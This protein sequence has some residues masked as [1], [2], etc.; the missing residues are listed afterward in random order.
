MLFIFISLWLVPLVL[1]QFQPVAH[2]GLKYSEFGDRIGLFGTFDQLSFY[3]FVNASASLIQQPQAN[4]SLFVQDVTNNFQQRVA[5][6]NGPVDQLVPISSTSVVILGGF[7]RIN[8]K[9]VSHTPIIYNI[10]SGEIVEIL[11]DQV[12][13]NV[14]TVY[15]DDDLI[16][17]GGDFKFNNTYSSAIYDISKKQLSITPFKGFESNSKITSIEKVQDSIIFA[18]KFNKLG[19]QKNSTGNITGLIQAEQI[20]SLKQAT[21]TNVNSQTQDSSTIIC[22]LTNTWNVLANEGG[23]WS[24]QFQQEMQGINPTKARLYIPPGSNGVKLFRIYSFPANGIMNLSYIDP[25]TNQLTFCDAWCPLTDITTLNQ[26]VTSQ[27]ATSTNDTFIDNG[28]FFKYVDDAMTNTLGYG[29][30]FQEFSFVN[31]IPMDKLT[32]TVLDWFGEYGSLS[33]VELF[34]DSII[35]YGNDLLNQPNCN[36]AKVSHSSITSGDFQSIMNLVPGLPNDYLVSQDL[37][38]SMVFYPNITYSGNYS[39]DI[40][41]PGCIQDNS[42]ANRG[43]VNVVVHNGREIVSTSLIHQNNENNKYDHLYS[44]HFTEDDD[45]TVE[46]TFNSFI[47]E[48]SQ[49]WI[50]VDK[51]TVEL[52]GL[53]AINH[54][55]PLNGLFEYLPD[56]SV[57]IT[58]S[59]I[60]SFATSYLPKDT[61]V[62]QVKFVDD[63]LFVLNNSTNLTQLNLESTKVS[64]ISNLPITNSISNM[65]DSNGLILLGDFSIRE[66]LHD[67]STNQTESTANN[68]AKYDN[69]QWFSFG[70]HVN[71][72]VNTF[73]NTTINNIEYYIFSDGSTF[74]NWDNSNKSWISPQF[75]LTHAAKLSTTQQILVGNSFQLMNYSSTNQAYVSSKFGS[76]DFVTDSNSTISNSFYVNSSLS[77]IGGSFTSGNITNIAL[78]NNADPNTAIRPLVGTSPTWGDSQIQSLY[79]D[80]NQDY[81]FIGVNGPVKLQSNNVT[82]I[83]VYSLLNGTFAQVQPA[84]LS[85]TTSKRDDSTIQVNSMVMYDKGKKLLVGGKFDQAGS[86]NCVALCVYDIANTRWLNPNSEQSVDISGT[87][88][89]MKFLTSNQAL[90]SGRDLKLGDETVDFLMYNFDTQS[91]SKNDALNS[92]KQVQQFIITDNKDLK[93]ITMGENFIAGFDGTSWTRIDSDL[94]Y[95]TPVEFTDIKLLTVAKSTN[96]NQ[97]YF[98][99][100][101]ILIL[102]GNFSLAQYGPV[103]AALFNGSSWIPYIFTSESNHLGTIKSLLIQDSY[104]YQS[105][106]DLM[107]KLLS[108]GKIVGISFAAAVGST[109]V[110]AL[111]Y[112]V[113]YL[114]LFKR[115][116][117]RGQFENGESSTMRI[118]ENE[119]LDVVKP[120]QLLHEIDLQRNI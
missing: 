118:K 97:T 10:D 74:Y 54:E 44:G 14:N 32:I 108:K 30:N 51:I 31:S 91:F 41:T 22:P 75:N 107:Q 37:N 48:Q 5:D 17:L 99:N 7:S 53:D 33:G 119:M 105:S 82:G 47:Q 115:K 46:I 106:Q 86:L 89:D 24:V 88:T 63:S 76:F 109:V 57:N 78:V 117:K 39:I 34:S 2:P 28:S 116:D 4:T 27:T 8:N 101:Q 38:A 69:N 90:I 49:P 13:G 55:V 45:I 25:H 98:N 94:D 9:T 29:T 50:V 42:C 68:I 64:S 62:N 6:L 71:N 73:T 96:Y 95:S 12:D 93:L 36:D 110:L 52:L 79:V 3:T 80:S 59:S 61:L 67:L 103:N 65:V 18:G 112:I 111:L 20:V 60:N 56:Q 40:Y 85:S 77:I 83:L 87:I 104:R 113:P 72:T 81:L 26:I 15:V 84:T 58:N 102:A 120:D 1:C 70:N 100:D 35:V 92:G 114:I 23:E 11:N 16:Y 19:E 66:D 21:F 43:I